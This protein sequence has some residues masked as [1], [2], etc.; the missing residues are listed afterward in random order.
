VKNAGSA[1]SQG[2][3]MDATWLATERLQING[4]FIWLDARYDDFDNAACSVPQQ[5]FGQPGCAYF[6]GNSGAGLQ[7][8]SGKRFAPT[9]TGLAGIGYVMPLGRDLELL[10]RADFQYFGDQENPRD[11]TIEQDSRVNL[12]LAATLRPVSSIGWSVGVLV[13][14][15][16]D[17]EN[18]FYEFEAPSQ[19]GTR[20]GYPAPP[21]IV[22][23]SA[24]YS[25]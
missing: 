4:S 7:D 10:M 25:M 8:L 1:H 6:V 19:I 2:L 12:D 24:S 16:T 18:Y 17:E 15:A 9:F 11:R 13:Q 14:N 23:W 3:E 20:I 22:T 5:A 21:R